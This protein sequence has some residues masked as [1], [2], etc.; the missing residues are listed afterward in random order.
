MT[1]ADGFS[2]GTN[3]GIGFRTSGTHFLSPVHVCVNKKT[4][5]NWI[6]QKWG[7]TTLKG[8]R[9]AALS[10]KSECIINISVL[11][12][13]FAAF[14]RDCDQDIIQPEVRVARSGCNWKQSDI[15]HRNR[16]SQFFP[17]DWQRFCSRNRIRGC[18]PAVGITSCLFDGIG[19]QKVGSLSR[20]A[21][22]PA[23]RLRARWCL[24][25]SSVRKMPFIFR[26]QL[27]MVSGFHPGSQRNE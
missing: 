17:L 18:S 15:F 9:E 7:L 20:G 22:Q 11:F 4:F 5:K 8:P 2:N 26:R 25:R 1:H 14:S 19:N 12:H 16:T 21:I 24:F 27:S 10:M 23:A 6:W 13:R 3:S